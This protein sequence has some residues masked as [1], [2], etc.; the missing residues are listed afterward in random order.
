MKV[1]SHLALMAAA[2]LAP[3][4]V[5]SAL[6][7]KML[8][9]DEREAALRS[10]HETARA[11]SLGV[12]REWSYAEGAVRALA[13]SERLAQD[14]FAGFYAQAQAIAERR[15]L[16]V[17]LLGA[18]GRQI[19]NTVVPF[20]TP[21]DLGSAEARERVIRVQASGAP[22]ISNLIVGR[23]T[24]KHVASMELAKTSKAGVREVISLWFYASYFT[25]AFPTEDVPSTWLI[26]LFDR[27]GRTVAR[28]RGP[29][30]YIAELPK[31]DLLEAILA[32]DKP[33]IRN[34]SRDGIPLYTVIARS[35]VSGWSVA[36]GVPVR[37]VEA[38]ATRAVIVTASGLLAAITIAIVAAFLFGRRLVVAID[39]ASRSAVVLGMGSVPPVVSAGVAEVDALHVALRE[40][41]RVL[42]RSGHERA[43]LLDETRT[44]RERADAQNK[45]K[46]EFLAM[47]GHE[48][49]NPLGAITAGLAL[50]E[51]PDVSD[52]VVL[53]ARDIMR[54]QCALLTKMVDELLDASRVITGKVALSRKTVDLAGAA[55]SALEALQ[56]SDLGR[57]HRIEV[58]TRPAP[59][60]ADPTRLGQVITNLLENAFKY[61]PA[62]GTIVLEVAPDGNQAVLRVTDSGMGMSADLLS[63]M[64]DIFVQ[65]PRPLNR[66]TGG[67]GIGLAVV[68]SMVT[69]HG[70][71]VTAASAGEGLGS[72]FEVRIP[73]VHAITEDTPAVE[74]PV[75][76]EPTRILVIDDNQDVRELLAEFLSLDGYDVTQAGNGVDGIRS[77]LEGAPAVAI[78]DIGLPDISGYEVAKRL[79]ADSRTAGIRLIALTGYGQQEDRQ[80]AADAGFGLHLT[81]PVD[82]SRL[83]AAL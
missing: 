57:D 33:F 31:A 1:R 82:M 23:A 79:R 3:V 8:L 21:I 81:K 16:H 10:M 52:D 70:G 67:L 58:R 11:A 68:R 4:V 26:G 56:A 30:E 28:N 49:R 65:G 54:R 66:A 7:L 27:D 59:V 15:D 37:V 5:F 64:F 35:P 47:L 25:R 69:Q 42:E 38:A 24:G 20:G 44:A 62:G 12:D 51:R 14:D 2:V 18:D 17:A 39:G 78:I 60:N 63:T 34:V 19:F 22:Q 40:A 48:L 9:D 83:L 72:T 53:R 50:M 76:R 77:A 80:R 32:H 36:V 41:G 55:R 71:I 61:T 13:E 43:L 45:A 6:A 46:D 74:Y 75:P 73:L 29:Q